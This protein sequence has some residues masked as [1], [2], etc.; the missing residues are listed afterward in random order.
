MSLFKSGEEET[1]LVLDMGSGSVAS[2]IAVLSK[3][4][5]P[6]VMYTSRFPIA[7]TEKPK[8][9][10]L[11]SM[12]LFSMKDALGHALDEGKMFYAK[13]IT[14]KVSHVFCIVTSPW[15]ISRTKVLVVEK[16][17]PFLVSKKYIDDL[18]KSESDIAKDTASP[19]TNLFK[20]D[21]LVS[22]EEKIL[23][24]KLNGYSTANPYGKTVKTLELSLFAS[25]VPEKV[26]HG[27]EDLVHKYFPHLP[28]TFHTSPL[29]SSS[30]INDVFFHENN[31]LLVD[32]TGEV[33]DLTLVRGGVAIETA[34][35]P[36]GRNTLVRALMENAGVNSEIALSFLSLYSND[37]ADLDLKNQVSGV[38]DSVSLE[39]KTQLNFVLDSFSKRVP[40]PGKVFI[41]ALDD[42]LDFF[43]GAFDFSKNIGEA[44]TERNIFG[45]VPITNETI[46]HFS[47]TFPNTKPDSFIAIESI[48]L[49]KLFSL[50]S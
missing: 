27:V 35:F 14:K 11:F 45:V 43:A 10:K 49:N 17:T 1:V 50:E 33:T 38:V 48:F 4:N 31:F 12:I 22:V 37:K 41:M 8:A 18:V 7:I 29:V 20:N 46:S 23:Q 25:R 16:P 40:L 32:V 21:S 34:S 9:E 24:T 19:L 13:G 2:G 6:K 15:H 5:R 39:W 36:V 42:V 47:F 26:L 30:V 3:K 28:I 44:I